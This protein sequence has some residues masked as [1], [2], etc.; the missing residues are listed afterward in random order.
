MQ[1]LVTTPGFVHRPPRERLL[2]HALNRVRE[3][4]FRDCTLSLLEELCEDFTAGDYIKDVVE[5]NLDGRDVYNTRL[6]GKK[7][8]VVFDTRYDAIVTVIE[9]W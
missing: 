8:R 4:V 6:W 1:D 7:V 3:R 2:H 5:Q 9:G